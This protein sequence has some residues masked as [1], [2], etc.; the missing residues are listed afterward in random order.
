[1]FHKRI[2]VFLLALSVMLLSSAVLLSAKDNSMGIAQERVI[3]LSA[4][5]VVG[6]TVLPA[7]DYKV[8]HEMQGQ[9]HIMTFKRMYGKAEVQM[10]CTLVPLDAKAQDTRLLYETDTNNQR[11][12]TEMIF[13]G[14][15]SK[16]VLE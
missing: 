11:V 14:D 6:G 8:T 9:A 12:L 16:H 3:T 4:P 10:K 15:T 5:T 2:A 7:G 1:M 13:R